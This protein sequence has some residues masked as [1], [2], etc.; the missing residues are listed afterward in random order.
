[1]ETTKKG[2]QY[3]RNS[4]GAGAGACDAGVSARPIFPDDDLAGVDAW[5]PG[6]HE[7]GAGRG[8]W[9]LA[10]SLARLLGTGRWL[11]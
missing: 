11:F 5:L 4:G 2:C 3:R 8:E 10:S 9:L 1:M 7:V 6:D